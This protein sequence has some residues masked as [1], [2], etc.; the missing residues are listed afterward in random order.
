LNGPNRAER[1]RTDRSKNACGILSFPCL[2]VSGGFS[3]RNAGYDES[4]HPDKPKIIRVFGD[5][6]LFEEI[7]KYWF[8]FPRIEKG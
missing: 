6:T 3:R 7:D 8:V 1:T 2:A 4:F 5:K